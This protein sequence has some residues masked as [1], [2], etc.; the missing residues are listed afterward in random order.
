VSSRRGFVP[1]RL[2]RAP[3]WKG[4]HDSGDGFVD[5]LFHPLL[6]VDDAIDAALG[7][8]A[9]Q[10]RIRV[11]VDEVDDQRSLVVDFRLTLVAITGVLGSTAVN[12]LGHT[13]VIAD[14]QVGCIR[15]LEAPL[16]QL[17]V[18]GGLHAFLE[19]PIVVETGIASR[20]SVIPS[21][22]VCPMLAQVD[23]AGDV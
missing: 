20:A 15:L 5:S 10:Q 22:V 17:F 3:R 13:R 4:S 6:I 11:C 1:V 19:E 7:P 8:P 12:D 23:A 21:P 2:P 14:D 18:D 9:P 16:P